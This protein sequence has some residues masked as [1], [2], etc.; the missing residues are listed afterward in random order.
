MYQYYI[1]DKASEEI[2]EVIEFETMDQAD[3]YE[4]DNPDVYLDECLDEI[5]MDYLEDEY[6]DEE[7]EYLE[8]EC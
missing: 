4:L 7:D 6:Y 5:D 2:I 1:I 3:Q 8:D